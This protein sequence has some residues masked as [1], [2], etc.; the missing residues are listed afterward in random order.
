MSDETPSPFNPDPFD[1]MIDKESRSHFQKAH[2]LDSK[3]PTERIPVI[4]TSDETIFYA[5]RRHF[6]A[7]F[8]K[9]WWP[10]TFGIGAVLII[11][12]WVLAALPQS[13]SQVIGVLASYLS[14]TFASSI[15]LCARISGGDDVSFRSQFAKAK[16]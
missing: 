8:K 10:K 11:T 12:F 1:E 16:Q 5:K 6:K 7:F 15:L 2:E 13:E 3:L 4:E 9:L 14:R